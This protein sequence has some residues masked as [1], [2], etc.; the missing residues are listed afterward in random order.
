MDQYARELLQE[1][2]TDMGGGAITPASA[3]LFQVNEDDPIKPDKET[4][5]MFHSLWAE[6]L[7]LG[8]RAFLNLMPHLQQ[9]QTQLTKGNQGRTNWST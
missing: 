8:K 4:S 5:D 7:F 3:Q 6:L 9:T 2:P 1:V